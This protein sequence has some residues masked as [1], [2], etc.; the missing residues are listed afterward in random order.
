MPLIIPL[1]N[2]EPPTVTEGM[3]VGLLNRAP[4]RGPDV[5]EEERR[6]DVI[7]EFAECLVEPVIADPVFVERDTARRVRGAWSSHCLAGAEAA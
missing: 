6:F 5:S 4:D 3:A 1:W 7:P 2:E